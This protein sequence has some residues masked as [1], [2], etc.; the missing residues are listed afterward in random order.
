MTAPEA[1][2]AGRRFPGLSATAADAL[3][4][5]ASIAVRLAGAGFVVWYSYDQDRMF[6]AEHF[7]RTWAFAVIVATIAL[8]SCIPVPGRWGGLFAAAGAGIVFFGGANVAERWPGV[9]ALALGGLAGL[10]VAARSR[11]RDDPGWLTA[12]GFLG[13][14]LATAVVAVAIAALIRN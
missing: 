14:G 4:L 2:A 7:P 10:L 5:G 1:T 9:A 12:A 6:P 13:A 11:R 8:L 3:I